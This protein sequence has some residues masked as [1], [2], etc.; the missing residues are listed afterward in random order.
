MTQPTPVPTYRP[1]KDP[2]MPEEPFIPVHE[3]EQAVKSETRFLGMTAV[4]RFIVMLLIFILT[5]IAGIL[6]LLMTGKM[7]FPLM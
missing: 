2:F 7:V 3:V 1:E 5:L 6:L 4:Q